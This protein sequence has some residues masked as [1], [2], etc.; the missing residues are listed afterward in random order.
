MNPTVAMLKSMPA[1]PFV[2][3][4]PSALMEIA[5]AGLKT[6][7]PPQARFA[8]NVFVVFTWTALS[9]TAVFAGP[10]GTPPTHEAPKFKVDAE[11]AFVMLWA[12]AVT[13]PAASNAQ[14]SARKERLLL[15]RMGRCEFWGMAERGISEHGQEKGAFFV[16]MRWNESDLKKDLILFPVF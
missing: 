8:P 13:R 14:E 7:I 5:P 16:C 2:R 9:H 3:V 11:S 15:V 6:W 12:F 10:A 1:E 4:L